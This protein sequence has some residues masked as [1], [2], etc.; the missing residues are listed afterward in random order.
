MLSNLPPDIIFCIIIFLPDIHMVNIL[1]Q[2]DQY[3]YIN[4]DDTYFTEW[5][6][7]F[8]GIDFW[9]RAA[10][11]TPAVSNPLGCMKYELMRL[12]RFNYSLKSINTT[13]NNK[14]YYKYWDMLETVYLNT[15]N[16]KQITT[17][18]CISIQQ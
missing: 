5:G 4:I 8:Y 3:L 7:N 12:E 6:R 9:I 1:T 2:V 11:R 16:Q 15:K 13:W 10:K 17:E 18:S 14:D